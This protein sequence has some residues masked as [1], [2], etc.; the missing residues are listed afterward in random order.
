M[1]KF[2]RWFLRRVLRK[3]IVQGHH[4]DKRITEFY[5]MIRQ[6]VESEFT[7]DNKPTRDQYL[8]ECFEASL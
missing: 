6:A 1:T 2:E 7:E 5:A 4:H 3:H 8:T